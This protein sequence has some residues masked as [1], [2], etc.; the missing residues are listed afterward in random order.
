MARWPTIPCRRRRPAPRGA[1]TS[2]RSRCIWARSPTLNRCPEFLIDGQPRGA[3]SWALAEGLRGAADADGD[4]IITAE[5]LESQV[6][7]RVR[8]VSRGLQRPQIATSA[9]GLD[10][11]LTATTTTAAG[12]PGTDTTGPD[13]PGPEAPDPV[14][15]DPVPPESAPSDPGPAQPAADVAAPISLAQGFADLPPVTLS[16][17]PDAA[18]GAPEG[19]QLTAADAPAD[20]VLDPITGRIRTMVGDLL[21]TVP[22]AVDPGFAAA[23]QRAVDSA[24]L[25]AALMA[26]G[27]DGAMTLRFAEGDG[28]Y[29]DGDRVTVRV[30]GRETA[31]LAL[32]NLSPDGSITPLYPLHDPARGLAD[33]VRIDPAE[34]L[35]LA[36]Q[37][38]APFGSDFLIAVQ[39]ANPSDA[40]ALLLADPAGTWTASALWEALQ[41]AEAEGTAPSVAVFPF[42]SQAP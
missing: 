17:S 1:T 26:L 20:L 2:T 21:T 15:P 30:L 33:P 37:V 7:A 16:L 18:I 40:I 34:T 12:I 42:H 41:M 22:T 28:T 6:R 23:L 13:T 25:A 32:F 35:D 8:E 14:P 36:L 5:E 24:R 19:A 11:V 10:F 39:T 31:H 4:G 27:R 29:A 9:G 3:L 38:G